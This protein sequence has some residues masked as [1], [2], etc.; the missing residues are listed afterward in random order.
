MN[1]TWAWLMGGEKAWGQGEKTQRRRKKRLSI[2]QSGDDR[3][4]GQVSGGE[5]LSF[6]GEPPSG[7]EE[8]LKKGL[9][10]EGTKV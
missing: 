3:R 8:K 2:P 9:E 1:E 5:T 6:M 10:R 4:N 7:R